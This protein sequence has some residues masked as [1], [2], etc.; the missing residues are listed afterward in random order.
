[1]DL[2]KLSANEALKMM[3][4]GTLSSEEYVK[5]FLKQSLI[6]LGMHVKPKPSRFTRK[7]FFTLYETNLE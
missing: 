6:S 4:E 5:A 1:M 2:N 3:E 7:A